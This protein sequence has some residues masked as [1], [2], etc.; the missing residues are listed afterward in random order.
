LND[1]RN[2]GRWQLT[3]GPTGQTLEIRDERE[4]QDIFRAIRRGDD[5]DR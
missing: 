5:A 3:I 1:T 2:A 4:I